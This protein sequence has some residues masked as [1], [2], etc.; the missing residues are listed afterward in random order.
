MRQYGVL[1]IGLL[2]LVGALVA[3]RYLT[4][5]AA[6]AGAARTEARAQ[7]LR[8]GEALAAALTAGERT[9]EALTPKIAAVQGDCAALER[10]GATPACARLRSAGDALKAGTPGEGSVA[11]VQAAVAALRTEAP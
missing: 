11:E 4:P 10:S 2:V 6:G 1:M 5:A 7:A 3:R 8:S 9:P